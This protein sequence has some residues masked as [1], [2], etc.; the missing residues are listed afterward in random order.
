MAAESEQD[1]LLRF[2]RS[3][4]AGT[5][6]RLLNEFKEWK[7]MIDRT[8]DRQEVLRAGREMAR[9]LEQAS[10][11][12]APH[13]SSA[14]KLKRIWYLGW[15]D[16]A[17]GGW[18][19]LAQ[20]L[21]AMRMFMGF[22]DL[23]QHGDMESFMDQSMRGAVSFAA[24]SSV[25]KLVNVLR[26]YLDEL[27]AD[28]E[29][30]RLQKAYNQL[31][32]LINEKL[33]CNAEDVRTECPVCM[34]EFNDTDV[35]KRWFSPCGHA[36]CQSCA[37]HLLNNRCPICRAE[38]VEEPGSLDLRFSKTRTHSGHEFGV[39]RRVRKSHSKPRKSRVKK[40]PRRKSMRNTRKK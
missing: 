39:K 40:S 25:G 19:T 13:E 12:I 32:R 7:I 26:S 34:R 31:N 35:Q 37:D 29:G 2:I 20:S 17:S 18:L 6:A 30:D 10:N 36:I 14:S 8:D 23:C 24:W 33:Q 22:N 11:A 9:I 3:A 4:E 21:L 27:N 5:A 16:A 28:T 15:K 38:N 1:A